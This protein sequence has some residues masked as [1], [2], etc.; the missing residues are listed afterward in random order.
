M[1]IGLNFENDFP[2][3]DLIKFHYFGN[4]EE[5]CE[6][7]KDFIQR[8][9]NGGKIS[10]LEISYCLMRKVSGEVEESNIKGMPM[11]LFTKR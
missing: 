1:K 6:N 9:C 2:F 8:K 10:K 5:K 3:L 7:C 4:R 11:Y